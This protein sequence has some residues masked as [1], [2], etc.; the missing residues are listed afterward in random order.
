MP[1]SAPTLETERLILRG[2]RRDDLDAYAAT[3]AD[4]AVYEQ[5]TGKPFSREDSWRRLMMAVGQWPML[6]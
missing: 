1:D 3:M 5:L 4:P 6:G 2:V